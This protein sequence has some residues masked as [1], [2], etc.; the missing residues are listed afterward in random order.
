MVFT[1]SK[2]INVN[3]RYPA[4]SSDGTKLC[5]TSIGTDLYSLYT[6]NIA[7]VKGVPVGSNLTK[8][9]DGVAAGG[10]YKQGKWRPGQNQIVCVFKKTGDPDN[11]QL[12]PS[13][14]GSPTV[15]YTAQ[16]TDWVIEDD[17][18]FKSDGSNLVFSERQIS[19]GNVYLKIFDV[20]NSQII[21][22]ID[23]T[24]F[25]SI[26]NVNN[27][28]E[29]DWAKSTGSNKVAITT[30]PRCDNSNIGRSGIHQLFTIDISAQTPSLTWWRN[31]VGNISFSS[32]DQQI[33]ISSG[34]A[35]FAGNCS[36]SSYNG[37][38]IF[39]FTTNGWTWNQDWNNTNHSDWKR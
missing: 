26:V 15:L 22:S 21:N 20:N 4:W 18:A 6:L 2:R 37:M 34:L 7:V 32:N 5:L 35:R 1:D 19:T 39:T 11:I 10:N 33:T 25:S 9:A 23:M 13:S 8:I 38:A 12:I 3:P 27:I 24:Q 17:I 31:D 14:G 30:R 28:V 29:L 36:Y 16:N